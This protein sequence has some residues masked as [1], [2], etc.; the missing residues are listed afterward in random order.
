MA[1][2]HT[3]IIFKK[4]WIKSSS[5]QS[6]LSWLWWPLQPSSLSLYLQLESLLLHLLKLEKGLLHQRVFSPQHKH[7]L[8]IQSHA[9]GFYLLLFNAFYASHKIR[10]TDHLERSVSSKHVPASSPSTLKQEYVSALGELSSWQNLLAAVQ[11]PTWSM[12][13]QEFVTVQ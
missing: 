1:L 11:P 7:Y 4:G 5:S 10:P 6:Q 3:V 9:T 13:R 12:R 2:Q 8:R